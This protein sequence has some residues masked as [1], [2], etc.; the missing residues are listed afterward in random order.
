[1]TTDT[2]NSLSRASF[3]NSLPVPHVAPKTNICFIY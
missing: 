1:M 3:T 2:S